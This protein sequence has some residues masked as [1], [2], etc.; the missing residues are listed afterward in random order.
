MRIIAVAVVALGVLF[1]AGPSAAQ[2]PADDLPYVNYR[3][4]DDLVQ[5]SLMRPDLDA[6]YAR[7]RRPTISLIKIRDT[8]VPEL[9]KS[10]E[11]L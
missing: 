4:D 3:F 8:F 9:L 11:S 10:G 2:Q 5:T 7:G 1:A 6:L